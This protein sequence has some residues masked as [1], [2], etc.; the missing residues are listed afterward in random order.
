MHKLNYLDKDV[1]RLGISPYEKLEAKLELIVTDLNGDITSS[2]ID[3]LKKVNHTYGVHR[4]SR[5]E[6]ISENRLTVA[7][8]FLRVLKNSYMDRDGPF[9]ITVS[10][11]E[12]NGSYSTSS[13]PHI[14]WLCLPINPPSKKPLTLPDSVR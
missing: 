13:K 7:G 4:L 2:Y 1:I 5:R 11:K 10:W 3:I 14:H 12:I 6:A 8:C 9:Y